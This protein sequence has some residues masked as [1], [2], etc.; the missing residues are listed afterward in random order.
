MDE[1]NVSEEESEEMATN[2]LYNDSDLDDEEDD[3]DQEEKVD[4]LN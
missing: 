3:E 4:V 2:A 1:E